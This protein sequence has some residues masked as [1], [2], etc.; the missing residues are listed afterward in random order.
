M[1]LILIPSSL[2]QRKAVEKRLHP[3]GDGMNLDSMIAAD[4]QEIWI[5]QKNIL[6]KHS[7]TEMLPWIFLLE[8]TVKRLLR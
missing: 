8:Q 7:P 1:P 6:Q 4:I 3:S 5:R 2:L